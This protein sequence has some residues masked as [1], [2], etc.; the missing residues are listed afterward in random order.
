[1][2]KDILIIN[3]NIKILA[4]PWSPPV[5]MKDNGNTMG[6]SL[7]P[8]YYGVYAQYFVKYIQAMQAQG[9]RIDAITLK[10]NLY[11]REIIQVCICRQ[12]IRQLL[13]KII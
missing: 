9:I 5:W 3:P 10:T 12:E 7:K 8:E 4:T 6:G 2:L 1:M 13:L 11:I